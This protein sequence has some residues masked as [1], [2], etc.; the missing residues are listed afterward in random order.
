MTVA[1]EQLFQDSE[2]EIIDAYVK[3]ANE[4]SARL[5]SVAGFQRSSTQSI[6]G[7]E[8]VHFVL[9]RKAGP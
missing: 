6:D 4:A 5:F 8:A 7:Q 3:P 9:S 1:A 2:A